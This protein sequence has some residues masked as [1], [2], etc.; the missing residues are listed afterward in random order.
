MN[1]FI[2]IAVYVCIFTL[3]FLGE[4]KI[5]DAGLNTLAEAVSKLQNLEQLTLNCCIFHYSTLKFLGETKI[6]DTGLNSLAE[7]VSKL[8]NLK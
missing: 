5:T 4:T 7:A 3:K 1:K 2:L 6:A 8:Q